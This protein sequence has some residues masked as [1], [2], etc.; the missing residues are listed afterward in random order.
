MIKIYHNN[1]CKKSREAI[2]YLKEKKIKFTIIEYLK[3]NL[4]ID[5]MTILISKLNIDPITLVR[6]N[7]IIWKDK[8]KKQDHSKL[9]IIKI[10]VSN[11]KLIERPIIEN[12]D[13]AVIGRP[14]ENLIEFLKSN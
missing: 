9:D 3:V 6:K 12:S 13:K 5:E 8:F 14:I 1:R 10:L 7:E 2:E 4:S 11:P